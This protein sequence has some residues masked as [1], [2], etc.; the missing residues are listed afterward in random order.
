M[1][2]MVASIMLGLVLAGGDEIGGQDRLKG[3]EAQI[4]PP[5]GVETEGV[6]VHD[7]A[8][9][10]DVGRYRAQHPS[11]ALIYTDE[12]WLGGSVLGALL[13]EGPPGN[14]SRIHGEL[15]QIG[16]R[17]YICMMPDDWM[18]QMGVSLEPQEEP[19]HTYQFARSS[20]PA[21]ASGFSKHASLC[22]FDGE[23]RARV[24]GS[25]R[26]LFGEPDYESGDVEDM[27]QYWLAVTMDDGRE[28]VFMAY[29]G[30]SGP[31]AAFRDEDREIGDGVSYAL[32]Q[33]LM[34]TPPADYSYQGYY[35][36]GP[37]QVECGSR[38]GTPYYQE[39]GLTDEEVQE[40]ME[41]R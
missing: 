2:N 25:L 3:A 19:G 35:W 26:A 12:R 18:E 40:L 41:A 15:N 36:D 20:A 39:R 1:W 37:A 24:Y 7:P 13:Y 28:A 16:G 22:G 34:E 11:T 14:I 30:P 17:E 21:D 29:S 6:V 4:H 33:L 31:S 32:K 5:I 27:Y 23:E 38:D 8:I 9:V 10:V